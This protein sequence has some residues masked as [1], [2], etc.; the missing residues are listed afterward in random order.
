LAEIF[1]LVAF[2]GAPKSFIFPAK[3]K[4]GKF[5]R[6]WKQNKNKARGQADER[7]KESINYKGNLQSLQKSTTHRFKVFRSQQLIGIDEAGL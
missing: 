6:E 1:L 2:T 5:V 4:K 7:S 3:H